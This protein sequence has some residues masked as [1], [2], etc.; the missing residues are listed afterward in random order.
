MTKRIGY[1]DW[2]WQAFWWHHFF[3]LWSTIDAQTRYSIPEELKQG[4]VVGNLAK[5]LDECSEPMAYRSL[6]RDL[7][8][9]PFSRITVTGTMLRDGGG[10]DMCVYTDVHNLDLCY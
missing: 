4:S 10:E 3:L 8:H 2:R 5:D 6:Q 9:P 1:R 7:L